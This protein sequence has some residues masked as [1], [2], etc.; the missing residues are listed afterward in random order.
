MISFDQASLPG[1]VIA[2]MTVGVA[3]VELL[4][5]FRSRRTWRDTVLQEIEIY[6]QMEQSKSL[7]N[8]RD[9]LRALKRSIVCTVEDRLRV[10]PR[11][12]PFLVRFLANIPMLAG[13]L[14]IGCIV[15]G[16][17]AFLGMPWEQLVVPVTLFTGMVAGVEATVNLVGLIR[18][19]G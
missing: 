2:V 15:L 3:A 4:L 19:G 13:S 11:P 16:I 14:V 17:A 9:A 18:R 5:K 8:E 6:R 7:Q 12:A 10:S 1:I